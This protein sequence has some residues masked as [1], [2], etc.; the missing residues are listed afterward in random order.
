[1][2]TA[3]QVKW[4]LKP[5]LDRNPDFALIR[6]T[7]FIKP[8][9]HIQ[10]IIFIQGS[11]WDKTIF[12]LQNGFKTP[13]SNPEGIGYAWGKWLRMPDNTKWKIDED[14]I[15][16]IV[17]RQLEEEVLPL[18]RSIQ[19]ISDLRAHGTSGM[20]FNFGPLDSFPLRKICFDAALGDFE[21]ADISAID[22]ER[23][24][25]RGREEYERIKTHLIPLIAKRDRA[26]IAAILHDWEEQAIKAQKLEKYWERTPF[27]IELKD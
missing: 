8:I 9:H 22:C 10:R 6:S 26:G 7:I 11:Y 18:L 23:W 27:P 12:T 16:E 3:A 1:M 24:R 15:Q 21:A 19:T 17:C 5:L 14:N 2:T 20:Y 4:L 13:F 25:F